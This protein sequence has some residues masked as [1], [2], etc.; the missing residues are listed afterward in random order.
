MR[1]WPMPRVAKENLVL[2]VPRLNGLA[3]KQ[4]HRGGRI[5]GNPKTLKY[6]VGYQNGRRR[7]QSETTSVPLLRGVPL[8]AGDFDQ[9]EWEII[10][11]HFVEEGIVD[12]P[13][14]TNK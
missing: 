1:R 10:Y 9:S 7:L 2:G 14:H 8:L 11:P 13:E 4:P 12:P 5:V 6:R 3:L